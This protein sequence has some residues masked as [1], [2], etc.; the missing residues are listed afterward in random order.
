MRNLKKALG[1]VLTAAMVTALPGSAVM[2]HA[3]DA[4]LTFAFV[5][6]QAGNAFHEVVAGGFQEACDAMG[7][8]SIVEHPEDTSAEKQIQVI[9]NLIAQGVDGIAI[10]ANDAEALESTLANAKEQGIH[11]VTVDSDTKGSEV[12]VNQCDTEVLAKIFI[13]SI[14]DL[15]GG[16]GQY[17]ILSATSTA[18]NQNA[19]IAAMEEYKASDSKFDKL[20]EVAVVYGDDELQKSYDEAESLLTNYPDLKVISSPTCIGLQAAVEACEANDSDV[21]CHG[22]GMPSWMKGLVSDRNCPYF[23]IWNVIDMGSTAAYVLKSLTDG[24]TTGAVGESFTAANDKE[25]T[26]IDPLADIGIYSTQVIMGD[27]ME[28]NADNIDE[29]AEKF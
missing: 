26:V 15:T 29:W 14:Y 6:K 2:V 27:P 8:K 16:E 19:W 17:A 13:D 5:S 9:N 22:L 28:L 11:I 20:E 3:E 10:A 21:I 25:Y 24:D 23:H 12:F 7:V 1:I 18:T 4:E